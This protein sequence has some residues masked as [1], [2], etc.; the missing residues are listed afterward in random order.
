VSAPSSGPVRL[1]RGRADRGEA[2]VEHVVLVPVLLFITLLAVQA[3][4]WFHA[5]NVAEHASSRGVS[6]ASR[7]GS[8][9]AA[10]VAEATR[11]A[12]DSG[13]DLVAVSVAGS[14]EVSASVTVRVPRLLPFFPSTVTRRAVEPEERFIP[15]DER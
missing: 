1:R 5:A 12:L 11:T 3:A 13:A 4:T 2:I 9:D 7:H 14:P 10:G 8:G 6:V 15:E